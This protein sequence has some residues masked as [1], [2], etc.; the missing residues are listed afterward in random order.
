MVTDKEMTGEAQVLPVVCETI[1]CANE[2]REIN[3]ISGISVE[4]LEAF[5]ED[6]SRVNGAEPED[7][8]PLCGQ[9]GILFDPE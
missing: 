1:G 3:R 9:R 5:I 7:F 2:G 4:H 8:C 6:W